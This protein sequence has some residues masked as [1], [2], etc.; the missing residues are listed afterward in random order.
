MNIV[1]TDLIG[2]SFYPVHNALKS[3]AFTH[4]WLKGG[5]GSLKSSFASIEIIKGMME[6]PNANCVA[7]RKVYKDVGES[8][9]EQ[10]CWAIDML[11]V[12]DFWDK[13]TSPYELKYRKTGQRIKFRGA[14]DPKKIKSTKFRKGYCKFI[15]YEEVD[16]FFGMEEIRNINQSLMRGG[17][18]F[19]IFYTYNPPK[20]TRNWVNEESLHVRQDKLQH[21]STYLEA[22]REWL[23]S[24]FINEA[25]ELKNSKPEAYRHEYLGE[26]TGT[27]TE[28]F[29][30]LAIRRISEEEMKHFTNV[31]RGLDWG[32]AG[33][34]LHYTAN[35]YDAKHKRLYIFEEIH[36]RRL[37]NWKAAELIKNFNPGRKPVI[38]D[39][40]EPKSIA[41]FI[42]LGI[43]AMPAK[44]GK[45]SVDYGIKW[46]QDLDQIIIDPERCP[47]TAREFSQ[48]ELQTD[49]NGNPLGTFPD[50]DNHSI[51]ATRYS[52]EYEMRQIKIN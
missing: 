43:H 17:D 27:G 50:K 13:K 52:R 32:F 19:K 9:Y 22:P 21:H 4:I 12:D 3:D 20:S 35:H 2:K 14:D 1:L 33:D 51:D 6:D 16:E 25:E 40:A 42:S 7:L 30:N 18:V 28:V 46:L 36:Q 23:G 45:D 48:Y 10:L 47:N 41:E 34:P 5:R 38:C 37:P 8:V 24:P 31:S 15:W 39:S 29:G 44:K 26:I 11:G 49:K